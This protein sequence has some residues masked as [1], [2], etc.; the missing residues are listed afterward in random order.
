MQNTS[1]FKQKVDNGQSFSDI[2][3]SIDC[4]FYGPG[5]PDKFGQAIKEYLASHSVPEIRTLSLFSG[6]GGLDI[7][8]SDVGFDIIESVEIESK[9]CE[10]LKLN[11]G[12]GKQFPDSKVNCIDIRKFSAKELGK[13]N[14]IIGGPPCQ[15]FSAAGR[16]ANGVLGTTDSRGILFKEYVRLLKEIRPKGFLFENVYGIIGAQHGEPW[17]E[18]LN[19]FSEAGYHLFYRILD[20]ADYGVP[21]HRERLII[22]GLQEGEFKFPRPTH[23][24]DSIDNQKFYTAQEAVSGLFLTKEEAKCGIGGR[25]GNLLDA[26]PPGL[27]YSFYTEKMGNPHPVFAW[28]SKFSDFLYKA[29]PD[30]PVRTIKASGGAYTGPFHWDNRSFSYA[31]YK[32]LQTFPDEYEISGVKQIAVKQIGNSV[33]PQ[34]ARVLAI[35]IRQQVFDTK[36]PFTL[37]L[38]DESEILGFRKRKR[39]LSKIY[40]Q[41]AKLAIAAMSKEKN[42]K[43]QSHQYYCSMT[44]SFNFQEVSKD[45]AEYKISATWE[46]SLEIEVFD[47]SN[48]EDT[49]KRLIIEIEID[50][51]TLKGILDHCR[52]VI[53][54]QNFMA[55]TVGWKAFE[56]ELIINHLKADLVQ[57]NGYYQYAPLMRCEISFMTPFL[58][59]RI[60][61]SVVSGNLVSIIV[62]NHELAK[63]WEIDESQ[64]FNAA[65]LLRKLGYE[66]RNHNTNPQ[67][68]PDKWLIPYAFPTL[69]NLSVQLR[70]KLR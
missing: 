24:P 13:I 33:P 36:F 50:E 47:A 46:S 32:R 37:S 49:K 23:G 55:F 30:T 31:E 18:I 3:T 70:K 39:E 35:A 40:Q 29:D 67:I 53:Y 6:A 8:F 57:L 10:T 52:I 16:R 12:K 15:T 27:N 66:I 68:E 44:S 1:L 20:A 69:T 11:S 48:I 64:I 9:F 17:R 54:S 45:V 58:G 65:E 34:L 59:S 60:L 51:T 4:N 22:V 26:I 63:E 2:C 43:P 14:F 7:G 5:W 56:H 28:R 38:L 61:E 62:S 25:Y 42:V 21:Q 41:K 19:S